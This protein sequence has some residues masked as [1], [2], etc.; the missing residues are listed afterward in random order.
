MFG[1]YAMLVIKMVYPLRHLS[2]GQSSVGEIVVSSPRLPCLCFSLAL[3]KY[4]IFWICLEP[5]NKGFL[6]VDIYIV[7]FLFWVLN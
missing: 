1:L 7:I 5:K 3:K 2:L 4:V 6:A